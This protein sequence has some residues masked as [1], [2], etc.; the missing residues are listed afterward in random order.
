MGKVA[1]RTLVEYLDQIYRECG[2]YVEKL[3]TLTFE[4]ASGA[5]QIQKLL[6][7]FRARSRRNRSAL[8][9]PR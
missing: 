5:Q 1:G 3:G 4:G 2:Y 8:S 9:A 7:S 6:A